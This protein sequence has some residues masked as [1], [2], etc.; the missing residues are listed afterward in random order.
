MVSWFVRFLVC[1]G[2]V[3]SS[4]LV[5]AGDD[6]DGAS[7]PSLE[8]QLFLLVHDYRNISDGARY[9]ADVRA[10]ID[11][12]ANV[13]ALDGR[14]LSVLHWAINRWADSDEGRA[15]RLEVV[16]LLL[17]AGA[18]VNAEGDQGRT[19]LHWCASEGKTPMLQ[20]LLD[21]GAD[22]TRRDRFKETPL[23]ELIRDGDI[24]GIQILLDRG[25]SMSVQNNRGETPLF[26]AA[27]RG[28]LGVVEALIRAGAPVDV[29][30]DKGWTAF[31]SA[32][33]WSHFE[34]AYVLLGSGARGSVLIDTGDGDGTHV[35]LYLIKKMAVDQSLYPDQVESFEDML[36]LVRFLLERSLDW[37]EVNNVVDRFNNWTPLHEAAAN[38]LEDVVRLLIAAK[39]RLSVQEA[40]SRSWTPLDCALDGEYWRI[41]QMLLEA[42][43][44][45]YAMIEGTWYTSSYIEDNLRA[46]AEAGQWEVFSLLLEGAGL[47]PWRLE[48]MLVDGWVDG[49]DDQVE[50]AVAAYYREGLDGCPRVVRL[51]RE[52]TG[53]RED[54]GEE[55]SCTE[56]TAG[57]VPEGSS[58]EEAGEASLLDDVEADI[59]IGGLVA[60]DEGGGDVE[61][62]RASL[63]ETENA[64]G[65]SGTDQGCG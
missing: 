60:L 20:L 45:T 50:Q 54:R 14:G 52:V 16:R 12:G 19:P 6:D 34:A 18:D 35:L 10:L 15:A 48:L 11:A 64:Q 41:A 32:V 13:C 39:A 46:A 36:K 40:S 51:I 43:A 25:A 22:V 61:I 9:I 47:A 1:F 21:S 27:S 65:R 62:G 23:Y 53:L 24:Q 5:L 49:C 37:G 42:G 29:L 30:D 44:R 7:V 59:D 28:D 33:F 63:R 31:V 57:D 26:A 55:A 38:G 3:F 58:E 17:E 8:E 4:V 2:F 56:V